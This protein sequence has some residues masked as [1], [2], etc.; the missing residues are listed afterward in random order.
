MTPELSREDPGRRLPRA[1]GD[2]LLDRNG[3]RAGPQERPRDLHVGRAPAERGQPGPRDLL[4][5]AWKPRRT[6]PGVLLDGRGGCRG[7]RRPRDHRLRLSPAP[8]RER[9]RGELAP[10]V[11][12]LVVT[13]APTSAMKLIWLVPALPLA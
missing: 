7:R 11:S 10:M 8:E 12:D 13:T 1:V 9:R 6:G 3:R 2:P 5:D 4:P